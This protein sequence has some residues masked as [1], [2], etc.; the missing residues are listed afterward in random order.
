MAT[1]TQIQNGIAKFIDEDIVPMLPGWRKFAFGAGAGL[2]LSRTGEIFEKAKS[3]ELIK[4][5]G[6]IRE[7]DTVDVDAIYREAKRQ[8][9]KAPITMDIPALGS[10]TLRDSDIDKLYRLIING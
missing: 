9:A 6:V 2:M 8:I 4:M 5:M 1:I 7:D 10:I 3:N